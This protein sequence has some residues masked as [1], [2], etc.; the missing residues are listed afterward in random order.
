M[1]LRSIIALPWEEGLGPGET[2]R[3]S[4]AHEQRITSGFRPKAMEEGSPGPRGLRWLPSPVPP[5]AGEGHLGIVSAV[6]LT[7]AM[8]AGQA[9]RRGGE[10]PA[11]VLPEPP[12]PSAPSVA[13][14]QGTGDGWIGQEDAGRPSRVPLALP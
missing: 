7:E 5:M 12:A 14:M 3:D 6:I 9:G 11:G 2:D 4:T 8:V 13:E 1:E 10:C